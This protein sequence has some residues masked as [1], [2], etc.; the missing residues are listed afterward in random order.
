MN[1]NYNIESLRSLSQIFSTA[2]FNKIVRKKEYANTFE[3]IKKHTTF[4]NQTSNNEILNS[5]YNELSRSY[6]SEYIYKN[7]LINK[8]LIKEYSL[9]TTIALN[10][11]KVGNSIAD[12][13]LLNGK[14]RVFEIKTE[15]DSLNKLEKQI[16]DYYSFA[17][18]VYIVTS[19]KHIQKLLEIYKETTVGIIELTKKNSLKEIKSAISNTDLL[20]HSIIFKSLRKNEYTKVL[21]INDIEIPNVPNTLYFKECLNLVKN[22]NIIEFQKSAI[23][24]LK[25]RNIKNPDLLKNERIPNYLK[26]ICY[27]LNFSKLEYEELNSFLN[28]PSNLCISHI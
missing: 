15:L 26:H 18:D 28:K 19:S 7:T 21:E 11:F 27:S 17:T 24:V 8:K 20:D 4:H 22:I 14:A 10:E 6:R 1:I 13:V 16:A 9:K 23:K 12:F 3:R 25:N 5:I 2:N